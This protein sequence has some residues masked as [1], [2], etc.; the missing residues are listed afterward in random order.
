MLTN[1]LIYMLPTEL[2]GRFHPLI[3]H[4]PIGI[5]LFAFALMVFQ[6]I[7]KMDIEVVIGFALFSGA[8]CSVAACVAGWILAQSGEYDAALVAK[9]QWT[10]IAT[11]VL[12]ALAFALKRFRWVFMISTVILLT[13]AGH[14]GGNLTH[15]EDYLF[16]K[17]K[18]AQ[19]VNIPNLDSLQTAELATTNAGNAP[20][21]SNTGVP[22]TVERK[23]FIYRD[24]VV[25]IL[26]NKCYSCHSATKM[27]G[28]LRLDTEA[29]IKKGGKN[30]SILSPGNPNASNIFTCLLLPPDDDQ[31][32]PPKGKPQLS[33]QE[34]AALHF[35]IKKGA[36]F[37]E[38]IE[39][40]T[41]G[42][43]N[44]P[45]ALA[46]PS[47]KLPELPKA[48]GADSLA[49]KVSPNAPVTSSSMEAAILNS[50]VDAA[51][52]T[53]L[54]QLQQNNIIVSDFGQGSNYLMANFVN[55]KKYRAALLDD[56][57]SIQDQLLRI[58][59]SNQ[60]IQDDDLK[61]L[62]GF[63]N[64]T[65]LNLEKTSISDAGLLHLQNLPKLE[66]LNLYGTNITDRGLL[67]LTKCVHLK[68]LYLWQTKVST[69]GVEQLKKAMPQLQIVMGGF[70]FVK[71]DSMGAGK[72]ELPSGNKQAL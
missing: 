68:T 18:S 5:L 36:S 14:Y 21:S 17:K 72:K 31:H 59:L 23:T 29:F 51:P 50:P 46:I 44:N 66:Q 3:V 52:P 67:A 40:I 27:K 41:I 60:P 62:A 7:R 34:I 28:G 26:E 12:A 9:H 49:A 32:M 39:I 61:K 64:L 22:Q 24:Y 20:N 16:P 65:W 10:G 55:V 4:L 71:P 45:T 56:L 8:L 11:T 63:K 15:G 54:A 48:P 25:P 37:Q 35:W 13:L 2:I 53:A 43:G 33:E 38:Q 6:R 19:Q 69:A 30:G 70:Q 58:R 1:T 42:A 47:L 57:K